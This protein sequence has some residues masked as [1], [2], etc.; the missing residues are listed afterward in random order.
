MARAPTAEKVETKPAKSNR[1][2]MNA[3]QEWFSNLNSTVAE[4]LLATALG[5]IFTAIAL[6]AKLIWF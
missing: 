4:C 5:I 2:A 6:I 3:L 1:P